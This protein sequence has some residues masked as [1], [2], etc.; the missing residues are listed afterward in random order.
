MLT[1]AGDVRR[2]LAAGDRALVE[3]V[4][5]QLIVSLLA[6]L[7]AVITGAAI[8]FLRG[9][10]AAV[11]RRIA[12]AFGLSMVGLMLEGQILAPTVRVLDTDATAPARFRVVIGIL[13]LVRTVVFGLM[14][15]R[16]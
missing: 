5:R 9:G 7:T 8:V 1:T 15:V 14:I 6:G 4:K 11:P 3:R 13:H 16:L 10:F 2:G 12:I